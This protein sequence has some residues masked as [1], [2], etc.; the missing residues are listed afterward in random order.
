MLHCYDSCTNSKR[1]YNHL[2][3]NLTLCIY[4]TISLHNIWGSIQSNASRRKVW[5]NISYLFQKYRIPADLTNTTE[6]YSWFSVNTLNVLCQLLNTLPKGFAYVSQKNS[7][8]FRN[9]H[10][11]SGLLNGKVMFSM[12]K[13][14]NLKYYLGWGINEFCRSM[15]LTV[16]RQTITT[17]V[18]VRSHAM[19]CKICGCE[20]ALDKYFSSG[21]GFPLSISFQQRSILIFSYV[22]LLQE[23]QRG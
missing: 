23:G 21:L 10:S 22:F 3:A 11:N 2:I 13:G 17:E 6:Q 14:M 7:Y 20:V 5:R 12:R 4:F 9:I 18:R 1:I 8:Y 19:Q 16:S 15:T